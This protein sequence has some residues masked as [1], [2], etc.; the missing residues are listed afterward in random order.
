MEFDKNLILYG[1]PGTGKT[2]VIIEIIL[3]ILKANKKN[4]DVEPK[5]VLLVSQSHPAVDKMLEDLIR[6]SDERPDLLR[7]GRDEKL[8]EEI[9]EEYSINDVKEKWYQNVRRICNDYTK[10][11]LEE[12]GIP[13][14]EFDKYFLKLENSKVENMDFSVEDKLFVE[15]FIKKTK[16]VKS[17]RTRK[18]LEI[19][20]EWTE[21]LKKCDEVELY[22]IKSTVIIAGTCTGFVSNRIIRDVEFDYVIV[23]EAA[24]ATFPELAVSLNKAHK[25]ILVGD[26]Q[27]LPPVLDTEIIRN[28]KEK[29]DEEGLAQGFFERMY[30]MFPE[31]NKHRLTIQYRM[32]PT[33]GTLISHV[34]YN[35]E[36]QNG[37]EAQDRELCIEGYEGIAIEW[38]STSKYS[39]KER[40]EKEF[41][42]NGKKSYQN[43][44]ERN[45][46][47]R[48][49][50]ELDSKLVKRTKVAVITG[51]GSQKYILQTM[52]KQHSFKHIEVDVDTVDAFQGSQKDIILYS[53]VRS[54]GN[55]YG[56]GFLKSEARINVAFSRARCLL[57]IVGDMKFLDNYKIRGNKFPEIIKYITESEGC[58]IIEK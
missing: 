47:E 19:Q 21:Q 38:I 39:T 51:Y 18:I 32:H 56:I 27:Q 34:F 33:I 36:I 31:D 29:L 54:S 53:T 35:D 52:V 57:I 4:P 1:P 55:K 40:Y 24:K 15:N 23:D 8:N 46:V 12:I 13:E 3:Q 20:R 5:K 45:I 22:I 49:L 6:E 48:K 42:N 43:Y 50:L 10:N 44:L 30:N 25:I 16:G 9:R 7:I 14:E 58:R 2:N 17:E 41:D 11:A 28:N 37:V 26:H